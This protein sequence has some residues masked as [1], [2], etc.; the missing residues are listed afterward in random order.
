[1]DGALYS[2]DLNKRG[3][4]ESTKELYSDV[5]NEFLLTDPDL[6]NLDDY[7]VF[8]KKHIYDKKSYYYFFAMRDFI[9]WKITDTGLKNILLKN[10]LRPKFDEPENKTVYLSLEKRRMII[11]GLEEEKHQVIAKIQLYTGARIGDIFKLKRGSIAFENY[12]GKVALKITFLAKRGR[13]VVKWIFDKKLQE[14]IMQFIEDYY[15]DDYYYFTDFSKAHKGSSENI[16][17]RSNYIW[18][19]LDL[20]KSLDKMGI[21]KSTWST[22]DF[23]RTIARDIWGDPKM[24]KDLELLKNFLG[25]QNVSTT[26]RYLSHS[27]LSN[28]EVSKGINEK[29][30]S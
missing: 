10:L 20:K 16:V 23:R 30:G 11:E 4:R 29:Y 18:Y 5:A 26:L 9:K 17:M 22:H 2:N 25:H 21:D 3:L 28:M 12:E 7:N 15:L 8:L 13:R 14:E 24:G 1:M 6:N 19:W 27:G